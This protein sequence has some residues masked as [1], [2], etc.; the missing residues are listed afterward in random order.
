MTRTIVGIH[1]NTGAGK[2][3]VADHMNRKHGFHVVAFAEA[4]KRDL[5]AMFDVSPNLFSD[6]RF[7]TDATDLLSLGRT[8]HSEFLDWY[9]STANGEMEAAALG[10]G[11]LTLPRSPRWLMQTYGTDYRRASNP[12]YWID[13]L[14]DT[15][16]T[17]PVDHNIVIS[18]VR[19]QNEADFVKAESSLNEV[20][21]VIRM[22]NPH[23]NKADH[24]KSNVRLPSVDKV[25][26]N[27]GTIN[28]LWRKVDRAVE[29]VL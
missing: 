20:W 23:H 21:E 1:G 19:F 15:I 9:V 12:N 26:F 5:V 28:Q 17:F 2:D 27:S 13:R 10:A 16:S 11:L 8:N 29:K 3:T 18:D 25:L 6:R 4:V 24:H 7:K 14:S 22:N